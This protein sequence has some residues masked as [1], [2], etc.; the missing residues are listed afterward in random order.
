MLGEINPFSLHRVGGSF[1]SESR[2]G[3][4]MDMDQTKNS[5]IWDALY[6]AWESGTAVGISYPTEALV[7]FLSN[8]AK[9]QGVAEYFDD[10]GSEKSSKRR[11]GECRRNWLRVSRES[12]ASEGVRLFHLGR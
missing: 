10:L 3:R 7:I 2:F 8:L 12:Q 6:K 9:G 4:T 5:E 11:G 1:P